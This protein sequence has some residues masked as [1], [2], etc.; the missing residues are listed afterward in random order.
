MAKRFTDTGKWD[1]AWFR[2]LSPTEKCVWLF[3]CDRCDHAGFWDVDMEAFQFFVGT[4]WRI[5]DIS[6]TFGDRI[7]ICG[8]KIFIPSFIDF[9][10]GNLNPKNRVHNSIIQKAGKL[11]KKKG[12]LSPVKGAMEMDMEVEME[13]DKEKEDGEIEKL[14]PKTLVELWNAN[15]GV[16]P[17]AEALTEKRIS[18]SK[19]QLLKHPE[20]EYWLGIISRWLASDFCLVKW[21]PNFDDLVNENKR[22]ATLE[23]KYDNRFEKRIS[24][25]GWEATAR[26]V[27]EALVKHGTGSRAQ[28]EILAEL[29][30][31]LYRITTTAGTQKIRDVKLGP[32]QIKNIAAMLKDAAA[33][34]GANDV[35][36]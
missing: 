5:E 23:G 34:L 24:D 36:V 14:N 21:K 31:D 20:P 22:V 26:R 13:L 6:S 15:C 30:H 28:T 12:R 35:A 27:L 10:Y 11:L 1:K 4:T 32:F 29:G 25:D 7:Q 33:T 8:D 16:L 3:L 19:A 2:K 18:H 9:Q 17:K